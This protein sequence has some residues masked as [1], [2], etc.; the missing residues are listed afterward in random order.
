VHIRAKEPVRLD[1]EVRTVDIRE[2]DGVEARD[3]VAARADRIGS[4]DHGLDRGLLQER[5]QRRAVVAVRRIID[6]EDLPRAIDEGDGGR[7]VVLDDPVLGLIRRLEHGLEP[8]RAGALERERHHDRART[9]IELD[10]KTVARGIGI[11]VDGATALL[12]EDGASRGALAPQE[13]PQ[14]GRLARTRARRRLEVLEDHLV[15][16]LVLDRHDIDGDAVALGDLGLRERVADVLVAVGEKHDALGRVGRQD[17]QRLPDAGR[18]VGRIPFAR[19]LLVGD[20]R[21]LVGLS[22]D[23][24]VATDRD[25]RDAVLG[26]LLRTGEGLRKV[27]GALEQVRGY[28]A[29]AVEDEHRRERLAAAH[30]RGLREREHEREDDERAEEQARPPLP[31]LLAA[32]AAPREHEHRH[33][34]E[35]EQEECRSLEVHAA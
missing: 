7:T 22:E 33:E 8:P 31:R 16:R 25:C 24:G 28:R 29:A 9:W 3:E 27:A 14:L 34:Q 10:R 12:E 11:E 17:R 21:P 5:H 18:D 2:D 26:L 20:H 13:E 23:D 32:T 19:M 30:P 35:K 4:D 15:R 1:R 6:D